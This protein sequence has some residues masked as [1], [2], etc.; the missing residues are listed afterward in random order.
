[1]QANVRSRNWKIFITWMCAVWLVTTPVYYLSAEEQILVTQGTPSTGQAESHASTI[2][3]AATKEDTFTLAECIFIALKKNPSLTAAENTVNVFQSR[4]GQAQSNYYPQLNA[5]GAYDKI[6]SLSRASSP[7]LGTQ[8]YDYYTGSVTLSQL[9]LDFGKTSSQVDISKYNLQAS[10]SDLDSTTDDI[11]FSVK[12]AYYGILQAQ[13]NKELAVELV[14]Q[15]QVHRDQAKGFY[16]VGT[17]AKIDVLRAD[18]DLSNSKLALIRAENARKVAL[19]VLKNAMGVPDAKDRPVEDNLSYQKYQVTFDEALARANENRPDLKALAARR[20]A[21]EENINFAKKG[22]YP[23]LS[24][25]AS[26]NWGGQDFPLDEGWTIGAAVTIPLFNG[27]LTMNQ[28]AEARSNLYVLKANEEST[29]QQILLDVQQAYLSLQEAEES[30]AA[31]DLAVKQNQENLDLANGRYA[32]GV[33]SP[34][35]ITD[36]LTSYA[37][38]QVSYNAALYNYKLAQATIEKAMGVR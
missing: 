3:S 32:A 18:V 29:R 23:V 19:V 9:L 38:A 15:A 1:M 16:E 12:Q 2:P 21:A 10:R 34:I 7:V 22:Y 33:G 17:R 13:R 35:E 4:V 28:V 6:N 36:A 37:N 30:I 26:Y 25:N 24:G 5:A 14:K 27:F 20:Q 11:I 8:T 31:A